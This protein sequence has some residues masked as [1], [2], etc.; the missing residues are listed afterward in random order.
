M[1][2][3]GDEPPPTPSEPEPEAEVLP[4]DRLDELLT[5]GDVDG[6]IDYARSL[7][8]AR[9]A[10]A[11]E[12]LGDEQR[13]AMLLALDSETLADAL[14][15]VDSHFRGQLLTGLAP[16]EISRAISAIP[17]D[18]ATDVVQHLDEEIAVQV[19]AEVPPER[20]RAIDRLLAHA[21]DTA[22]GRMTGQVVSVRPS[23]TVGQ[24]IDSLRSARPDVSQPFYLY[25]TDPRRRLLGVL[26]LRALIA[27]PSETPITEVMGTEIVTVPVDADQEEAARLLRQYR[28]V[29]L[30]VLDSL[31]HL[32]GTVTSDDLIDVLEE[33]ATEDMFRIVGV[34][35][36]ED[37]RGVWRS[38]RHRLPWLSVNMLTVLVA[39]WVVSMFEGTLARVALLAAFLPVIAGIG[40]N[41]G[42]QTLTVVVRSLA[43]GRLTIRH[44]GPTIAHEVGAGIAMGVVIGLLVGGIATV[45]QG[46]PWLGLVI[47]LALVANVLVGV[48]F[49]V[50][51][52]MGL[53]R[54]DQDPAL[55]G[56]IWLTT[57]TD[58]IGFLI[59]LSLATLFLTR[60][61]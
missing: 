20:R 6:A 9:L 43:L 28:L 15:Y 29:A 22:G 13:R 10:D 59:Y 39:A 57:S 24:T 61:E 31:G 11:L 58:V 37:L 3:P 32:L 52:P 21:E 60:I 45:W 1:V 19:L 17:D 54:L 55:S 36:D 16:E 40:G 5:E 38:V 48:V 33:E 12:A 23:F 47:A 35:E 51:I 25:V 46:E 27:A 42:I 18:I 56:G 8:P 44:T 53:T 14:Y 7:H 49:G 2:F 30:P 50:L 4:R 41:A 26:N 34:N